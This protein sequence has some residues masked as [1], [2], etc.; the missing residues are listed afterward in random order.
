MA[1]EHSHK[2]FVE[3]RVAPALFFCSYFVIHVAHVVAFIPNARWSPRVK[4]RNTSE[5]TREALYSLHVGCMVLHVQIGKNAVFS[6]H[7]SVGRQ[8]LSARALM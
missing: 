1:L 5:A 6:S 3:C 7:T 8:D 4:P 2:D